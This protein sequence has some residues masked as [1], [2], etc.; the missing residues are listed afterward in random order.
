MIC[1]H[2]CWDKRFGRRLQHAGR[3]STSLEHWTKD[4]KLELPYKDGVG[5]GLETEYKVLK[6]EGKIPL[7]ST[8]RLWDNTSNTDSEAKWS[9]SLIW[10][11]WQVLV[12]T[13]ISF[14]V[15]QKSGN[16]LSSRAALSFCRMAQFLG[17]IYF[18]EEPRNIPEQQSFQPEARAFY[19]SNITDLLYDSWLLPATF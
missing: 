14:R 16:F 13:A 9:E 15:P 2:T 12:K 6:L 10:N 8:R 1:G 7:G 5:H 19:F 3:E 18:V 17:V 4:C 11:H